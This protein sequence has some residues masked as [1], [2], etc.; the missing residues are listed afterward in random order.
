MVDAL[1]LAWIEADA[2]FDPALHARADLAVR[3]LEVRAEEGE[4][5]FARVVVAN[6][7]GALAGPRGQRQIVISARIDGTVRPLFRGVLNQVP[8][9]LAGPFLTLT[10]D[11]RTGDTAARLAAAL[12][13]LKIAPAFD[14]LFIAE[15]REDEPEE[16]LD[17]W[18]ARPCIDRL[19][20]AVSVSDGLTGRTHA[21]LGP[22]TLEE[23]SIEITQPQ[24][25][26]P[27]W[28]EGR[29]V[30]AWTQ[31]G[32]AIA[33][34]GTLIA[35][36][37]GGALITLSPES[38]FADGWPRAG[39][40]LGGTS[41]YQIVASA[42]VAQEVEDL[43]DT[44]ANDPS[45]VTSDDG[46]TRVIAS[47]NGLGVQGSVDF[48]PTAT[49]SSLFPAGVFAG[50][51]SFDKR[52]Y[53]PVLRVRWDFRQKRREILV[54]RLESHLVSDLAGSGPGETIAFGLRDVGVAAAGT[55]PEADIPDCDTLLSLSRPRVSDTDTSTVPSG[56]D[57][58]TSGEADT[59]LPIGD[60]LYPRFAPTPRG[61]QAIA[62]MMRVLAVRL[63]FAQRC[64]Q[65]RA[66]LPGWS[67]ETLALD[68]DTT[69]TLE[70]PRL[71]GGKATGKVVALRWSWDEDGSAT[72]VVI[73]CSIGGGGTFAAPTPGSDAYAADTW[74]DY[75]AAGTVFESGPE[76]DPLRV[77]W[78]D[79]PG[80]GPTDAFAGAHAWTAADLIGRLCLRNLWAEQDAYIWL[81]RNGTT[82][83]RWLLS[84]VPTD[85]CLA[86]RPLRG[87]DQVTHTHT[88]TPAGRFGLPPSFW[89]EAPRG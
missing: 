78:T 14:P 28:I 34:F 27:A 44:L 49:R 45:V 4:A 77:A 31:R 17:G 75:A 85:V 69:V 7:P 8:L 63:A 62:H 61:R 16:I 53:W 21:T 76:G 66:R 56:L 3:A 26:P 43:D 23:G 20:G 12:A 51:V 30:V 73:A 42:L 13:P 55:S 86:L 15:G 58:V 29:A 40:R 18:F 1:Y 10:F 11:S 24:G 25:P 19:S 65:V 35:R 70:S 48:G 37:A 9:G 64:V 83:P 32:G 88:L 82:S 80:P 39:H 79:D 67:A 87:L 89:P 71:P 6:G 38:E 54:C 84:A 36:E 5:P 46:H 57:E 41:G 68:L 33:D 2:A 81:H 47:G 60:P 52:A 22:E 72:E 59:G 50:W 74:E